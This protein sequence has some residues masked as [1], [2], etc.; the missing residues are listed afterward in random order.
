MEDGFSTGRVGV[1]NGFRMIQV[2][3]IY[4][5]LSFYYD[6]IHFTSDHQALDPGVWAPLF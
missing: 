6:Y 2:Y 3:C 1:G 5:A 4:C